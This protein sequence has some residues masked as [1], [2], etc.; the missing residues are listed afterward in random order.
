MRPNLKMQPDVSEIKM[1]LADMKQDFSDP[2]AAVRSSIASV[3]EASPEQLGQL[4]LK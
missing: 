2:Q 4:M 1:E 3:L